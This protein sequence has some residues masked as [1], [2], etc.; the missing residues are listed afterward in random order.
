VTGAGGRTGKLVLQKLLSR[1][2]HFEARGLV[3]T[4]EVTSCLH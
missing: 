3:R 1:Q 2:D 4:E